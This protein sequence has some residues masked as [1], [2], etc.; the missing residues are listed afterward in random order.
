MR[1]IV[2]LSLVVAFCFTMLLPDQADAS[3]RDSRLAKCIEAGIGGRMP[4]DV[5]KDPVS[6]I[7]KEIK[8]KSALGTACGWILRANS[9]L[10]QFMSDRDKWADLCA[11]LRDGLSREH[12]GLVNE[13]FFTAI[14]C[15]P[16][17]LSGGTIGVHGRSYPN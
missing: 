4:K 5:A 8:A 17:P 2:V 3:P 11:G 15:A 14:G 10:L 12:P 9:A 13:K 7:K 6:F 1:I 16:S